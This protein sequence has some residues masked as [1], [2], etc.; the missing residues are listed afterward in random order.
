MAQ[1]KTNQTGVVGLGSMGLP[2]ARVLIDKGFATAAFDLSTVRLEEAATAGIGVMS[3]AKA[4]FEDCDVIILSLPKGEH[5]REVI[6]NSSL[7]VQSFPRKV[8][9]DT[10][11]SEA[12]TS[13]HLAEL[14]STMGHGFLDAPVS[15]GPAGAASGQLSFM[16]GGRESDL[17]VALPQLEALGSKIL[18]VGGSGSGNVTKLVNNMLVAC[19]MLT[20]AEGLRLAEAAGVGA[21]D[22]L[23]VINAAS[24][25]T[26]LS[27]NHFPNHILAGK[28]ASG[29]AA[30]LMRK[31]IRLALDL[32]KNNNVDLPVSLLVQ[33]IWSEAVSGIPGDADFT[34]LGCPDHI[35]AHSLK[36][37]V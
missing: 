37:R 35:S 13:R 4:V 29:F 21:D 1:V 23:R 18:H 25:R 15:G 36:K 30:S 5:V 26:M 32:A 34:R 14:L 17:T 19:H 20:T 11:T 24:G 22:A 8:I 12:E 6:E 27:E 28:F 9:I 7:L 31:D 33:E 10:S 16:V 3:S 2:M